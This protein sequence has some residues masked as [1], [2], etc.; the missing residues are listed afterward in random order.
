MIEVESSAPRPT[1]RSSRSS[2]DERAPWGVALFLALGSLTVGM[3]SPLYD[4][5]VPAFLGRAG[6][7]DSAVGALMGVDN[8]MALVLVPFFGAWSD[9]SRSRLGRR[10]PFVAAGLVL[11]AVGL[12]SIPFAAG[13]GIAALISAMIL[14]NG[15][16]MA[17]RA[18]FQALLPD[19]VPS[20]HRSRVYGVTSAGMC[21]GAILIMGAARALFPDDPRPPFV[22][23]ASGL[24]VVGL[25]YW[26]RL[27]EPPIAAPS[28]FDGRGLV[29]A[30]RAVVR[31]SDR[32]VLVFLIGIVFFQ[33]AFQTFSS[34]F[35]RHGAERFAVS[36]GVAIQGFIAV[37]VATFFGSIAA[38]WLGT[39]IGRRRAAVLGIAGMAVTCAAVHLA[40]S[41]GAA[42]ALLGLFGLCWSLPLVNTFPMA[43][44]LCGP[45]RAGIYAALFF[46]C[47]GVAGELGPAL[48][49]AVFDALGDN[50]S[51]FVLIGADLV[52]ALA[53]LASLPRG[54]AEAGSGP[55]AN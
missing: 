4:S 54:F 21:I 29:V 32:S 50:R 26:F 40:P 25:I 38:G 27:R 18:P 2:S 28:E 48:A 12:A 37:A 16:S 7:S 33:M 1:V 46:V 10:R 14:V 53:V 13:L 35:T 24:A 3:A 30:L 22:L 23:A 49:G 20:R 17:A 42:T 45:A 5:F 6:L 47:Q 43:V 19:L 34:W 9:R 41:L 52:V 31:E 51:L 8:L 39:R 15:A 44:E 55:R 11:A 36:E